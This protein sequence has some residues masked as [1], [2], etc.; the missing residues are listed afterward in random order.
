MSDQGI[1]P[2]GGASLAPAT[3]DLQINTKQAEQKSSKEKQ[4]AAI[5]ENADAAPR[6]LYGTGEQVN[7]SA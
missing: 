4:N 2:I 3:S 5:T 7:V 1:G 6:E